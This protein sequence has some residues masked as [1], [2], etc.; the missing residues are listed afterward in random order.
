MVGQN[1]PGL[2][3]SSQSSNGGRPA[4]RVLCLPRSFTEPEWLWRTSTQGHSLQPQ[5]I[6]QCLVM[7]E[8][9]GLI[10]K[11]TPY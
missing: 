9:A 3:S 11:E 10:F 2:E 4:G 8:S 5:G 7:G 6:Q 1:G